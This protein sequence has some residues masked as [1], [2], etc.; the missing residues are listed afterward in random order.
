MT[1][2]KKKV[3]F[4]GNFAQLSMENIVE[5]IFEIGKKFYSF[6]ELDNAVKT[7]EKQFFC[8]LMIRDSKKIETMKNILIK[9]LNT[10]LKYYAIKY[11]CYFGNHYRCRSNGVR[12]RGTLKGNCEVFICLRASSEGNALVVKS[13]NLSH[14]HETNS[15]FFNYLPPQRKIEKS[16]YKTVSELISLGANKKLIQAK[17]HQETGKM[18]CLKSIHNLKKN[19]IPQKTDLDDIYKLLTIDYNCDVRFLANDSNQISAILFLDQEMKR[20]LTYFPDLL[21]VDATYKLLDSR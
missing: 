13:L 9:N 7:Y 12:K 10:N 11:I 3:T 1:K 8:N 21:F 6:E 2:I 16:D 14:N 20:V 18:V 5:N 17:L 19:D 4:C 15:V